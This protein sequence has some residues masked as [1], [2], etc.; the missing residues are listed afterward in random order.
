MRSRTCSA[1]VASTVLVVVMALSSQAFAAKDAYEPDNSLGTA[2]SIGLSVDVTSTVLQMHNFHSNS[3]VDYVKFS[4]KKGTSYAIKVLGT[5]KTSKKRWL[6]LQIY[7]YNS[8]KKKWTKPYDEVTV[9]GSVNTH[10]TFTA[11]GTK[12]AFRLR[13]YG[14]SGSGTNY[15]LRIVTTKYPAVAADLSEPA[16][17]VRT[18]ATV[19]VAQPSWVDTATFNN[20]AVYRYNT[21]Y[22]ACALHSIST[23]S[24][25]AGNAIAGWKPV[26]SE[27]G[28]FIWWGWHTWTG[29]TQTIYM[30]AYGNGK[31]KFWYRIGLITAP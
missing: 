23:T 24:D 9:S 17:N 30:R 4:A 13:P 27:S 3:D 18:S 5:D 19:L 15:G 2:K 28:E 14:K 31:A 8:T 12:Y 7:R 10:Y 1:L 6:K 26:Y 11:S 16:D 29:S 22:S 20:N 25:A 21:V